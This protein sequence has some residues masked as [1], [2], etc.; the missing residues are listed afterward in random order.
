MFS[1]L[2]G[3]WNYVFTRPQ[4]NI[5]ILGLDNA[6]K[7]T[8]L[9]QIKS[10]YAE[11]MPAPE[12]KLKRILP[13]VGQNVGKVSL[14]REWMHLLIWDLGG[15]TDFRKVWQH[16]YLEAHCVIFVIDCTDSDRF[17]EA[18]RELENVLSHED[19][20][21]SPL[22]LIGN[23]QDCPNAIDESLVAKLFATIPANTNRDVRVQ[24]TCC[25]DATGIKDGMDWVF[26]TMKSCHE[27]IEFVN[28][29]MD[30]K[31]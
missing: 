3:I 1:L 19:L 20:N 28:Q 21:K 24:L 31:S 13:T 26:R 11:D 15:Q 10:L 4:Y 5:L 18:R 9:T 30:S 8:L 29:A 17:P 2:S 22:L 23:K 14:I 12:E 27:R 25:L 6:G 7:S 16:Y